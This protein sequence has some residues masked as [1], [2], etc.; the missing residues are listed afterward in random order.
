MRKF[1]PN[2]EFGNDAARRLLTCEIVSGKLQGFDAGECLPVS[3]HGA[4]SMRRDNAQRGISASRIWEKCWV[5]LERLRRR[6]S[7]QRSLGWFCRR[8]RPVSPLLHRAL[9]TLRVLKISE[10]RHPTMMNDG[11]K[12]KKKSSGLG[13]SRRSVALELLE[14]LPKKGCVSSLFPS[15][16]SLLGPG[17][18]A[19]FETI[20]D[21]LM[22]LRSR[23]ECP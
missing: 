13:S 15:S 16:A 8:P 6:R 5:D 14:K 21:R 2:H 1:L 9:A 3:I 4:G 18:A 22:P 10:T 17:I 20:R 11:T 12:D 7:E 23:E 19:R